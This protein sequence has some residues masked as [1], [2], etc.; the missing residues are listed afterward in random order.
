MRVGLIYQPC[1]LGDILFLQKLG[2]YIQSLGY[3]IYWPVVHELAWLNDYISDFKFVSWCDSDA[4]LTG[5]PLPGHVHFPGKEIYLPGNS[6]FANNNLF[7]FQGSVDGPLVMRRKYDSVGLEFKDWR[8]FVKFKRN[9]DREKQ[10]LYELLGD[11]LS[12]PYVFINRNYQTR[13]IRKVLSVISEDP[14]D[15]GCKVVSMKLMPGYSIFDWLSVIENAKAIYMVESALN[16]VLESPQVFST[17]A[18]KPL[19][20]YS[21]HNDFSQVSYLFSLPWKYVRKN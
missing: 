20:L 2:H 4:L 16:Y 12:E 19:F 18:G 17:I 3:E 6:T 8:L 10:L 11:D 13:P 21:R 5:P 7:F 14:Q 9:R 15:Y 1:G